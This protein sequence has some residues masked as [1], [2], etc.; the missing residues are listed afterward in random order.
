MLPRNTVELKPGEMNKPR[1]MMQLGSV[2]T[3]LLSRYTVFCFTAS[4]FQSVF[5]IFFLI[6]TLISFKG[7]L[8]FQ[9][10]KPRDPKVEPFGP[11]PK[12]YIRLKKTK[13]C[14]DSRVIIKLSFAISFFLN[15]FEEFAFDKL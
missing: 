10:K 5:F 9:S 13:R 12:P 8:I 3:W 15:L 2:E 7:Y 4:C 6:E 1:K 14:A 11:D